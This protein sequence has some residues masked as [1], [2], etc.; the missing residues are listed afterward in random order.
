MSLEI[1][2]CIKAFACFSG[3]ASDVF[4][5]IIPDSLSQWEMLF[6]PH[7]CKFLR[8]TNKKNFTI[9]FTYNINSSQINEVTHAKYLGV[10]ID[11][12]LT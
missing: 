7:K 9:T 11:Q 5:V 6:N 2:I 4:N 3:F 10:I 12:H 1:S 8:I